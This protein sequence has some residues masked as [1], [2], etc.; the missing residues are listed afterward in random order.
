LQAEGREVLE[1]YY[2]RF[3]MIISRLR[4]WSQETHC[5]T[6]KT[7]ANLL[8]PDSLFIKIII[9]L[10]LKVI[11]QKCPLGRGPENRGCWWIIYIRFA[12]KNSCTE[13][14]LLTGA[15]SLCRN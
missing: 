15:L 13:A 8:L 9:G 5:T 3:I 12:A 4:V 7:R 1:I 2:N 14:A 11:K 10:I 6:N